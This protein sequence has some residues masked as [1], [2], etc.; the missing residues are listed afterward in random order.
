M[1]S[2]EDIIKR[3]IEWAKNAGITLI[4]PTPAS[5]REAYTLSLNENFYQIPDPQTISDIEGGD[6][7]ELT[8]IGGNPAS[9]QAVHSS[10]ALP[11]NIFDY[12]KKSSNIS[13]I[14]SSCGFCSSKA[15]II[16]TV[17]YEQQFPV[18][19]SFERAP[20]LDVVLYPNNSRY[21]A[22]A[23]ECKFTEPYSSRG[24]G[25]L[26]D[27]Y[28]QLPAIWDGIPNLKNLA[29]QISPDDDQFHHLHPAQLIRHILGLKMRYGKSGFRLLYLW[30]DAFG[31]SGHHHLEEITEFSEIAKSDGVSFLHR[32]YQQ[33]ILNLSKHRAAHPDYTKYI[34]RRYL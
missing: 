27:K 1:S 31:V 9:I 16:G 11:V 7:G 33:V 6:G 14:A 24:H 25:G 30:Y 34:T 19:D 20:N 8:A 13:T 4:R 15:S 12:W 22:F 18:D 32:T 3:Q 26:S 5:A 23:T 2:S 17:R 28:L 10:S 21:S 29:E